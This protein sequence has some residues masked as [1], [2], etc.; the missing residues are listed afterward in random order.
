VWKHNEDGSRSF[1]IKILQIHAD[2]KYIRELANDI[3]MLMMCV[4]IIR[5]GDRINI[6]EFV[7]GRFPCDYTYYTRI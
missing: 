5:Q 1:I 6:K 3:V 2:I 7:G 4:S